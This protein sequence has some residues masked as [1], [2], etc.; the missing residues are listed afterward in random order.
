[1]RSHSS[2]RRLVNALLLATVALT[3]GQPALR[4]HELGTTRVEVR[5]DAARTYTIEI[6]TDAGALVE[7][8]GAMGGG[9]A[10]TDPNPDRLQSALAAFDDTF[11]R[12]VKLAFDATEARP[13]IAYAV[14][15]GSDAAS[16]PLATIRL[17]GA[18]P[19]GAD[20]F[21]WSYAWTFASYAMTI[22]TA[23]AGDPATEWLEGGQT[24]A[25]FALTLPPPPADRL[26]TAWR[27]LALGFTHIVP[28]GLDHMLFVLGIYLLSG[29]ARTVLWQ[30]SAF[31]VAHSITLGLG[32]Y[33]IVAVSPA[34]VEPLIALS[35]A[36]VAIENIFLSELRSWR[37]ALVFGF[38]LL[39][40]M[41]FAGALS[42]LGLPRSEFLT[43]LL[44]FNLGVEAGQLTVIGAAFLLV[45]GLSADRVWYRTRIVIPASMAIA[46]TAVY[47]TVQRL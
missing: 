10:L 17:T 25:P 7:K 22:R 5:F 40:G 38:G 47:W 37:V 2:K 16:P 43:A 19:P 39:H 35:I 12:R 32:I 18:I 23:A 31:T 28:H 21:S 9:P 20:R 30:V 42:E 11:R 27:Y 13:A 1:M 29:R 4:A 3:L 26:A 45:G 34:I 46:G 24:S 41:G 6:V 15:P 8:L 36:Y 14:S 33:G 44:T